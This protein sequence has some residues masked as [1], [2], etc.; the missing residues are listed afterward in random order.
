M[1]SHITRTF[2]LT[3]RGISSLL[4]IPCDLLGHALSHHE[5][6]NRSDLL[7]HA[8]SHHEQITTFKFC[9]TKVKLK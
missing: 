7:G 8:L 3:S 2:A 9:T 4:A 6:A 5:L 1:R